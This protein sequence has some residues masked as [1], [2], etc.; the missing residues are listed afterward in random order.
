[1]V[2][3]TVQLNLLSIALLLVIVCENKF[4]W[5]CAFMAEGR[6]KHVFL[7]LRLM[8]VVVGL[9]FGALWIDRDVGWGN[10]ARTFLSLDPLIFSATAGMYAVSQVV[11]GLRWWMLLRTQHVFISPWAAVKLN[12][13]GMFY[14]NFLPSSVGGDLVRAWYVTRHTDRGFEAVLSVFVDRVLG[15]ASMILLAL[16]AWLLFMENGS[17]QL[18]SRSAPG[19]GGFFAEQKSAWL[20]VLAGLAVIFLAICLNGRARRAMLGLCVKAAKMTGN[21]ARKSRDAFI[22]YCRNPF[23]LLGVVGATMVS[24]S[25]LL[26][27]FWLLGRSIGIEASIKYYF[28]FFPVSWVIGAL[29]LSI[30]GAVVVEYP[31]IYMFVQAAGV[32]QAEASVLALCQRFVWM[33]VSLPGAGIHLFGAHLPKRFSID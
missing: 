31:L 15:F 29:P 24:Q 21:A 27:I 11:V 10:L 6:R 28:V 14:N 30:G 16:C 25:I 4:F 5:K 26:V 1:M 33:I 20:Y 17:L 23:T 12:F 7:I 13:L 22:M 32:G 19:G 8:V 2:S 3:L 18:A 9:V